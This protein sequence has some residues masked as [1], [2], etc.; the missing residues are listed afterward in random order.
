LSASDLAGVPPD[1]PQVS[2]N[3]V[4]V[5]N[6]AYNN[7][8]TPAFNDA[9][10]LATPV[11]M[12][13]T[14]NDSWNNDG[15]TATADDRLMRGV[16]KTV[17]SSKLVGSFALNNVPAGTYDLIVYIN[18]NANGVALNL[19]VGA[20]TFFVTEMHQFNDTV[21]YVQALNTMDP[22]DPVNPGIRDVGN[23]VRFTGIQ[24]DASGA[25]TLK[26]LSVSGGDGGGIAAMQLLQFQPPHP[27]IKLG[28]I[29]A[30]GFTLFIE[31]SI[32]DGT[33][34]PTTVT[35]QVDGSAVSSVATK[36]LAG[37][38]T[39]VVYTTTPPNLLTA[40]LHAVGMSF[41]GTNGTAFSQNLRITVNPYVIVPASLAAG[42]HVNP[43]LDAAGF[44]AR[45]HQLPIARFPGDVNSNRNMEEELADGYIDPATLLPYLN[46]ADLLLV[47]EQ[48]DIF[49]QDVINWDGG[50]TAFPAPGAGHF[51]PDNP[52]P[53]MPG[54]VGR[55]N[56]AADIETFLQLK[57]GCYRFGVNS[58]DGFRFSFGVGRGDVF[59]L[60]AG[61]FDTG[62]GAA[63]T[64]FDVY[65]PA[66]GFYPIRCD[67][68]N[69]GGQANIEI[70]TVNLADGSVS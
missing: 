16:V 38:E 44:K 28:A 36:P 12:T 70:F 6:P 62:R 67:W 19:T 29:C 39:T 42:T 53:G 7:A 24:P 50:T 2:W 20:T 59:G 47:D 52:I 43:L 57:A 23:Y 11:T 64:I 26:M 60:L 40:G 56:D 51:T 21:G 45:I 1:A 54:A 66:D 46:Q 41:K 61:N 55:D 13:F 10:G 4:D 68:E 22:L 17:L 8:I 48:P 27:T 9:S 32:G 35:L 49:Y 30:T 37:T 18:V 34:D 14:A 65:I 33:V 69:G 3:N 31:D 58:D 5:S 63:D 25:I 15:P